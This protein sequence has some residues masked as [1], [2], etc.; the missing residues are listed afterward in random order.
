MAGSR[1]RSAAVYWTGP[2]SKVS[3][4]TDQAPFA[5]FV[6]HYHLVSFFPPTVAEILGE[7]DKVLLGLVAWNFLMKKAFMSVNFAAW[8]LFGRILA[9]E[10]STAIV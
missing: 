5:V 7:G 9:P 1:L 3:L 4:S 6:V 2:R 8:E 10:A